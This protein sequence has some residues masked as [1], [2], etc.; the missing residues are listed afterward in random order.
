SRTLR[1]TAA[2]E[3]FPFGDLVRGFAPGEAR[4]SRLFPAV[5]NYLPGSGRLDF[6]GVQADVEMMSP[7]PCRDLQVLFRPGTPPDDAILQLFWPANLSTAEEAGLHQRRL[8]HLLLAAPEHLDTPLWK[9]PLL[10][11]D[12]RNQTVVLWNRTEHQYPDH[13]GLH[14]L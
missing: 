4:Q 12:E 3:R 14:Q 11:P 10:P 13:R 1:E 9:I 5:L 6:G 2:H 8:L 7:G